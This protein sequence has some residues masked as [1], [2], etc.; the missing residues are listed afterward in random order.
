MHA[1]LP[2]SLAAPDVTVAAHAAAFAAETGDSCRSRRCRGRSPAGRSSKSLNTT[3]RDEAARGVA[4]A[5][6]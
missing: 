1:W 5:P 6:G 4:G 3:E 2:A